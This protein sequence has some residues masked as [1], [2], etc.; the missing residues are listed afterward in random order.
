[1]EKIAIKNLGPIESVEFELNDFTIFIG[2]QASGKSTLAKAIYFFKTLVSHIE[3]SLIAQSRSPQKKL[4]PINMRTHAEKIIN[5]RFISFWGVNKLKQ[6]TEIRYYYTSLNHVIIDRKNDGS[7]QTTFSDNLEAKITEAQEDFDIAY[8]ALKDDGVGTKS[9]FDYRDV[10]HSIFLKIFGENEYATY[11]PAGRSAASVLPSSV[12]FPSEEMSDEVLTSFYRMRFRIIE[13]FNQGFD[14][15][16]KKLILQGET[17]K[18]IGVIKQF[19]DYS[20]KILKGEY[21][22]EN[23]SQ[24]IY[25]GEN[26]E[27]YVQLPFA[28]SG[29]QEALWIVISLL[30][31][32]VQV[33]RRNFIV[34]EEPEAH[35]FP[36]TQRDITNLISYFFQSS[37]SQIIITTHSPYMLSSANNLLFAHSQGMKDAKKTQDVIV[38]D[39]W[40]KYEKTGVY[41]LEHGGIRDIIDSDLKMI[42][43][44]EIDKVSSVII[45]E[46]E[47]LEDIA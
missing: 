18:R 23:G 20:K 35:L 46:Y 47:H 28:S 40:L 13:W 34:I 6:N 44:E 16:E 45:N 33:R 17:P 43:V 1:M 38:S 30:Y 29:Q 11:L 37:N 36:I 19:W 4:G 24:R 26:E 3:S 12:L 9:W 41:F 32:L 27:D 25:F 7:I 31:L 10:V 14:G 2:P 42:R 39:F 15:V 5:N 22:T 8:K 21:R